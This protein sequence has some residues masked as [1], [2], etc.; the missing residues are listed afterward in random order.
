MT[1]G[2]GMKEGAEDQRCEALLIVPGEAIRLYLR[3][4]WWEGK[5]KD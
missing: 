3:G 4:Q 5:G 1:K 2:R